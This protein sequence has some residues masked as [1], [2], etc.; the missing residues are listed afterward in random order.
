M[1]AHYHIDKWQ[2][3]SI[4]QAAGEIV[5][6]ERNDIASRAQYIWMVTMLKVGLSP[7]TIKRC[8]E[9][10]PEVT[11][12]YKEYQTEEIGDFAMHMILQEHGVETELTSK[13]V[14]RKG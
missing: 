4:K 7:K 13:E 2:K 10:M 11:E 3:E 6:K 9:A 1:K 8:L 14:K 12:K 5:E